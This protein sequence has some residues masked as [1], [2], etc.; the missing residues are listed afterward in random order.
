MVELCQRVLDGLGMPTERALVLWCQFPMNCDIINCSSYRRAKFHGHG[1]GILESVLEGR[2]N[3]IVTDN[4]AQFYALN[5]AINAVFIL[6]RLQLRY[7]S[8]SRKLYV[9]FMDL[10]KAFNIVQ[11]NVFDDIERNAISF[12]LINV[13]ICITI[14]VDPEWIT[15]V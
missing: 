12:C 5:G 15:G 14:K 10:E 8:K 1:M 2:H 7:H 4:V 11:M 13:V 6:R 3:K 9:C